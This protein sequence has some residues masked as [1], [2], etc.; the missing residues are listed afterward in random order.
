MHK[1][2]ESIFSLLAQSAGFFVLMLGFMW[3]IFSAYEGS[4]RK[5]WRKLTKIDDW[6][7][8]ITLFLRILTYAGF[9]VGILSIII[10]VSGL[11]LNEPPSIAYSTKTGEDTVNYFTSIFLIILGFFTFLKPLN[12]LPISSIIGLAAATLIN[13][14]IIG[15]LI[16]LDI[17]ISTTIAIVII[18]LFIII[19]AV[20]AITVKF[21]TAVLMAVSKIISW[22]PIA[23]GIAVFC[24][25]QG[26][27]L[28]V[29]GISIV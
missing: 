4:R 2:A 5:S 14:I 10:G 19:F 3:L 12:D 29:L 18:V 28:L 13:I 15:V 1:L 11:I 21:Y 23:F 25:I 26:F 8:D 22:P 20:V 17:T 24:I 9:I 7:F 27:L 6:D 16:Y